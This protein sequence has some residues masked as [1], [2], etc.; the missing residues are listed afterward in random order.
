MVLLANSIAPWWCF[1]CVVCGGAPD[2]PDQGVATRDW[3]VEALEWRL[4]RGLGD[5]EEY[6]PAIDA[7]T[8]EWIG[9][10][11]EIRVEIVTENWPVFTYE[12][13]LQGPLIQIIA[14]ESLNGNEFNQKKILRKLKKFARRSDKIWDEE[15]IKKFK[16]TKEIK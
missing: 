12:P 14:L 15:L 5:C 11:T 13:L 3:V 9:N 2:W 4:D 6:M 8:L 1:A 7:W 16:E 10:S